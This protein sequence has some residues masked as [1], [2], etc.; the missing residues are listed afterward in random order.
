MQIRPEA[1]LAYRNLGLLHQERGEAAQA[2][3]AL[4]QAL[5]IAPDRDDVRY[6]AAIDLEESGELE[7]AAT[8]YETLL[9]TSENMVA[10]RSGSGR[11]RLK[12]GEFS[13]AAQCFEK[14]TQVRPEWIDAGINL[15][16]A[17]G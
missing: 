14:C 11:Y 16:I 5:R 1:S 3:V 4:E 2:A 9:Q 7:K 8:I 6:E 13:Q 15:A 10:A 17:H 12:L